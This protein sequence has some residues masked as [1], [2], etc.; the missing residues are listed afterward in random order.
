[1]DPHVA[2]MAEVLKQACEETQGELYDSQVLD[3]SDRVTGAVPALKMSIGQRVVNVVLF[4]VPGDRDHFSV[5]V[6][7]YPLFTVT[8]RQEARFD[9][10]MKSMGRVEDHRIGIAD[11]DRRFLVGGRSEEG[12]VKYFARSDVRGWV[13]QLGDFLNLAASTGFLRATFPLTPQ[14]H[15][16]LDD[17]RSRVVSLLRLADVAEG[18]EPAAG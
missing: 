11:F 13:D 7:A 4:D 1:M 10:L 14:T 2:R 16:T 15:D 5:I 6:T 17:L 9:W 8:L 18:H 12:I 3:S